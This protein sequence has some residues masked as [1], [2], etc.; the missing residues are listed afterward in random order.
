MGNKEELFEKQVKKVLST[1]TQVTGKSGEEIVDHT[2]RK[3]LH[4]LIRSNIKTKPQLPRSTLSKEALQSLERISAIVEAESS[5]LL[6]TEIMSKPNTPKVPAGSSS[7]SGKKQADWTL[8]VTDETGPEIWD[9]N[10]LYSFVVNKK[11]DKALPR[12]KISLGLWQI[13]RGLLSC[14][15]NCRSLSRQVE[16]DMAK[17]H[18]ALQHLD[19][20]DREI[21]VH[22]NKIG[23]LEKKIEE[24][25]STIGQL[26]HTNAEQAHKLAKVSMSVIEIEEEEQRKLVYSQLSGMVPSLVQEKWVDVDSRVRI[27]YSAYPVF[28]QD[29]VFYNPYQ[30]CVTETDVLDVNASL[31][32]AY[33]YMS[34]MTMCLMDIP[35]A[36][37]PA[38]VRLLS[39]ATDAISFFLSL[40]AIARMSPIVNLCIRVL[41]ESRDDENVRSLNASFAKSNDQ[42][43]LNHTTMV[44]FL[45]QTEDHRNVLV[46]VSKR[47]QTFMEA[48]PD[49]AKKIREIQ[50]KAPPRVRYLISVEGFFLVLIGETTRNVVL[51]KDNQ[52]KNLEFQ[53]LLVD[54]ITPHAKALFSL[55]D[56]GFISSARQLL[57]GIATYLLDQPPKICSIK[58]FTS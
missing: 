19:E 9:E 45:S 25:R 40:N 48:F 5:G 29:G 35:E 17:M 18:G 23:Q 41:R 12:D 49:A 53:Q 11:L 6:P 57:V 38:Y 3:D 51:K 10:T 30:G 50:A 7:S 32:C 13:A 44:H 31:N 21:R 43:S 42:L 54:A 46:D 14:R 52:C 55:M 2:C 39:S 28:C 16:L 47:I 22:L 34:I 1:I 37:K 27:G 58:L 15:E 8:S 33:P 24:L 20:K 36:V 26:E 4:D 56:N